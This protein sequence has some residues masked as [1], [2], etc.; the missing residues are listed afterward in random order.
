MLVDVG[1]SLPVQVS[2]G[3]YIEIGDL[4]LAV[5][6]GAAA[7]SLRRASLHRDE[8][9]A[10]TAGIF[11]LPAGRPLTDDE[12]SAAMQQ[13]LQLLAQ[14]QGA[15]PQVIASESDD[16]I[17]VRAEQFVFRSTRARPNRPT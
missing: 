16:G 4:T 11:E 5:G 3:D 10:N 8:S 7:K 12:L 15:A 6:I 17:Y 14:K 1:N 2:S 13:P 9:Y